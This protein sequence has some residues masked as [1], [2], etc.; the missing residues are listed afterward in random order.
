MIK[1][2][3]GYKKE[4][5]EWVGGFLH[6]YSNKAEYTRDYSL[7]LIEF[8]NRL[9][10]HFRLANELKERKKARADKK[11]LYKNPMMDTRYKNSG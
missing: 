7:G 1:D 5:G 11:E 6:K 3:L 9:Y 10:D 8:Q 4:D 2:C